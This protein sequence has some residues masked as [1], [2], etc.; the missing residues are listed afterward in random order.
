MRLNVENLEGRALMSAN[1]V[2]AAVPSGAS[3]VVRV[4]D[5]GDTAPKTSSNAQVELE[6]TLISNFTPPIG[7]NKGSFAGDGFGAVP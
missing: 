4:A 5:G 2:A 6:N 3:A 7:S 1:V